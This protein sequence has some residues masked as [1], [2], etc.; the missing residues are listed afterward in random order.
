M[1]ATPE[2][3]CPDRPTLEIT[4]SGPSREERRRAS[5][6]AFSQP[7]T[8]AAAPMHKERLPSFDSSAD[9]GAINSRFGPVPRA[10]NA[11]AAAPEAGEDVTREQASM[12]EYGNS[13]D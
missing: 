12:A 2:H 6:P 13:S 8:D 11:D 3:Q 5:L 1:Y 4:I 10:R 9:A 7:K